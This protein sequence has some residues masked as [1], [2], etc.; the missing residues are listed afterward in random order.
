MPARKLFFPLSILVHLSLAG[1]LGCSVLFLVLNGM[2]GGSMNPFTVWAHEVGTL[3]ESLPMPRRRPYILCMLGNAVLLTGFVGLLDARA[4]MRGQSN[5]LI[6]AAVAA[7]VCT[8]LYVA[9]VRTVASYSPFRITAI[10]SMNIFFSMLFV[11]LWNLLSVPIS[12]L[13]HRANLWIYRKLF[14]RG[15]QPT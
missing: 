9:A 15:P 3:L 14:C 8:I 6:R 2:S 11:A 7:L 10:G 5:G 12:A 1:F 13:S 4:I